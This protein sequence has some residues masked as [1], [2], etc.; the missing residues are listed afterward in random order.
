MLKS[1][2]KNQVLSAA[3]VMFV[4]F[5]VDKDAILVACFRRI[6]I[7]KLSICYSV[8]SIIKRLL[9]TWRLFRSFFGKSVQFPDKTLS[10]IALMNTYF[11][12]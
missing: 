4:V 7:P 2:A 6:C 8:R 10:R 9:S 3:E 5:C 11:F 1:P 12:P